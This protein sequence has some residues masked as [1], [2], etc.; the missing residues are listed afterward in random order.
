MAALEKKMFSVFFKHGKKEDGLGFREVFT[1][2]GER[3]KEFQNS[4]FYFP[5]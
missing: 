4:G 2:S 5:Q 1:F 3:L